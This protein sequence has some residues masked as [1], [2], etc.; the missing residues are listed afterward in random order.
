MNRFIAPLIVSGLGFVILVLG[1]MQILPGLTSAGGFLVFLGLFLLGLSFIPK[2][3]SEDN[4]VPPMS[5][6]ERLTKI[7]YAPAEV[8]QNLRRHPRWA[9]ALL[10]MWLVSGVY[11][12][13]FV[14]RITP[15]VIASHL[16]NKTI[17]TTEQMG[18][19]MPPDR[20]A[21]MRR[22]NLTQYKEPL[23]R[24][25]MA[26][27]NSIASFIGFAILAAIFLIAILAFGGSINYWQ[28]LAATVYAYFPIAIIRSLLSLII[29]FVKDPS[30]IH[31]ILGQ[32][33]LVT[34]NLGVLFKAAESPVL[35]SLASAIGLLSLY[36]LWLMATG[37][38]N[39]GERVSGSTAWT[40]ALIVWIFSVVIGVA[41]AAMFP[42]FLS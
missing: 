8:F 27:S 5:A 22:D 42:S 16:T 40:V 6:V 33:S 35:Y 32:Q 2:P 7:F 3:E 39:A 11:F 12:F 17:Q 20:V 37:L 14:Q 28:A 26:I 4:I 25:G 31:P 24:L 41:T 23:A 34:D 1:I 38:K 19:T 9:A 29:L 18:V 10:V 21:Q 36:W 30:D 15:D 13:A